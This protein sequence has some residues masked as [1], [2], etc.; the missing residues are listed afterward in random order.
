MEGKDARHSKMRSEESNRVIENLLAKKAEAERKRAEA[1]KML[2][3]KLKDA[4]LSGCGRK[5]KQEF[6]Q[7]K[8]EW[9]ADAVIELLPKIHKDGILNGCKWQEGKKGWN[10]NDR[11]VKMLL[12]KKVE[13]KRGVSVK[14]SKKNDIKTKNS[15][16]TSIKLL[17]LGGPN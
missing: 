12:V 16:K 2:V 10:K 13:D 4:A 1:K 11:E 14:I 7:D 3:K 5:Q 6:Q 15:L 17:R 8:N 9:V